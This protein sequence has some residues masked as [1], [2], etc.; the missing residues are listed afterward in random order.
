MRVAIVGIG[1]TQFGEL[2]D[3]SYRDL[4]TMAGV[5]AIKD[6]GIEGRDIQEIYGGSMSP[7][8]FASQEHTS[9]IISDFS[10]LKGVPS[11]RVEAACASGGLALRQG[12]L[13]IKSGRNELV[14]VGGVEKMTD[15][16]T[17]T[18]MIALMGAGDEEWE[19][20]QGITFPG[21]Y[22]LMTRRHMFEY[23]TTLE[24]ISL[25]SV[26][27]HFNAILNEKA[28]F[29]FEV[30]LE[31]VMNSPMVADPLRLLHCSPITDGA[32]ALILANEKKA[33]KITDKPIWIQGCGLA[34]D[35]LALH[36]RKSL[37]RMDAVKLAADRAYKTAGIKAKDIDFAEV[38]DAFAISEILAI[39]GLGFCKLGEGGK[40]TE[41]GETSL[42]GAIPINPSGGLKGKGHPV[43]ATGIA[44]AIEC[45]LQLRGE[46]GKRQIEGAKFGLTENV[47]GSG[48]TCVVHIFSNE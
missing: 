20:F 45:V 19:S 46:A 6:A 10:G 47:G 18:A 28:Q 42:K 38:H 24:Q 22:A 39:E 14:V 17:Q 7:G 30:T 21:L 29:K 25:V 23:K 9:A 12:M 13:S 1:M 27:N 11:V 3:Y 37:S 2:W 16:P 31:Q 44:Q 5:E 34:T 41:K 35:T 15:V 36:D 40:F 4:I 8:L 43:G 32:A 48:A 26:K 33:K